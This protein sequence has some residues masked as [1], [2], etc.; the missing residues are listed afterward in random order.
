MSNIILSA[1]QQLQNNAP[2]DQKNSEDVFSA[3]MAG[4]ATSA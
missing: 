3:I 2:L 1:I 4:E